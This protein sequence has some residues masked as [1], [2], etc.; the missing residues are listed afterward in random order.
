[1]HRQCLLSYKT[2][3]KPCNNMLSPLYKLHFYICNYICTNTCVDI[4]KI[5]KKYVHDKTIKLQW[6]VETLKIVNSAYIH[7]SMRNSSVYSVII[8][9]KK[10][11]HGIKKISDILDNFVLR[12]IIVC[13]GIIWTVFFPLNL[14]ITL[15]VAQIRGYHS[16]CHAHA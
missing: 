6:R 8:Q 7:C 5:L 14:E 13:C 15:D 4:K 2:N 1:M 10:K 12:F 9:S 3:L 11:L 16:Y